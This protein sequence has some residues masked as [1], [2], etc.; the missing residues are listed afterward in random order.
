[1]PSVKADGSVDLNNVS[2]N[3]NY[4]FDDSLPLNGPTGKEYGMFIQRQK[5]RLRSQIWYDWGSVKTEVYSR[6]VWNDNG[7]TTSPWIRLDNF[8]CNTLAELKAALA[9]V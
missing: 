5:G 2:G 6:Y 7:W 4:Y 3:I 1:M 9:N 8:G